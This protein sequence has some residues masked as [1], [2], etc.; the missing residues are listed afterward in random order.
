MKKILF[1]VFI[2]LIPISYSIDYY[3]DV[4][5]N[6]DESG[7]IT[8][9][10]D[11]NHPSFLVESSPEFTSKKGRYWLLNITIEDKFSNFIFNLELPKNA[12]INYLKTP[13]LARIDNSLGNIKVIGTGEG[14]RFVLVVQY[15]INNV[16]QNNFVYV[17]IFIFLIL[18]PVLYF[19]LK[20]KKTK[21]KKYNIDVL[22]DRQKI[23]FAFIKKNKK[24]TQ[25]QL[26][27]K[28]DMPKSSLSRNIESLVRKGFITKE[29]KGMTN[30]L[31]LK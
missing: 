19:L 18:L 8:I 10:G 9:K 25:A 1:L 14:Q 12:E 13:R 20:N 24:I 6:V 26:E 3:A 16:R 7:Y 22:T 2:L 23:I 21:T 5:I 27:K 15:S 30:I 29:K 28:L 31:F 17:I 11:T 4:D